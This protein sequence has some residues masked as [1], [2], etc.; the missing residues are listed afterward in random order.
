MNGLGCLTAAKSTS[1][2]V[3]TDFNKDVFLHRNAYLGILV[4]EHFSINLEPKHHTNSIF[5][6]IE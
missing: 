6:L 5:T 3:Q 1:E 2:E 4:S